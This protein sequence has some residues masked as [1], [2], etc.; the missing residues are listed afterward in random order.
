M[1]RKNFL[2]KLTE[3][4]L[5]EIK[6]EKIKPKE[7]IDGVIVVHTGK[8]LNDSSI[9]G[10]ILQHEI[11]EMYDANGNRFYSNCSPKEAEQLVAKLKS[12]GKEAVIGPVAPAL[13]SKTGKPIKN[14]TENL[15]GVYIVKQKEQKEVESER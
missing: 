13:D 11:L 12:Q 9:D 6:L 7:V 4:K 15:V 2:K 10:K 5:E 8:I 3:I 1:D 14:T